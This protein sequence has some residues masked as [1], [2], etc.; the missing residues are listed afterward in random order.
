MKIFLDMVGC[1]LNQSELESYARQLRLAGHTLAPNAESADMVII[2]TCMVTSAAA[3]DSRQKIRQAAH[4]GNDCIV[5]TGCLATLDPQEVTSLP[6]V[7]RLVD[8]FRKDDLVSQ[9]FNIPPATFVDR[10][11]QREPIPGTRL[12]TRAFIKV[13]DGCDNYCTYCITRLARGSSRSR[14]VQEIFADIQAA[15]DGGAQEIV[16][17][18]VHLGSWGYDFEKPA[19]LKDLIR[20]I[21]DE[22]HVPRL[23]LSS[24]EP[25]DLSAEFFHLWSD[26]R[27]CRHLH[28]PLQSGC[29]STLKRMGRKINPQAYSELVHQARQAVPGIAI[30]TDIITG[31][32]GESENEFSES[33]HFV[34]E[35]KFAGGHVFTYSPRPGTAAAGLPDQV[36]IKFA[37]ERNVLMRKVLQEGASEFCAQHLGQVV[38]VLWEKATPISEERWQLSGLS[39]NYLRVHAAHNAPTTNLIMKVKVVGIEQQGLSGEI[40][41]A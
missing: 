30:T 11:I 15:L 37:K 27:L 7:V 41:P 4:A 22:T 17:T 26:D 18:G 29:A 5:V 40:L 14:P 12:R 9:L 35:L 19:H 1:R 20:K 33:L 2:N 25:W 10:F 38:S 28:L 21:L 16:L 32:P 36:P 31:F 24:L 3:S 13:Q 23:H 8:N 39:D 34:D 6:G